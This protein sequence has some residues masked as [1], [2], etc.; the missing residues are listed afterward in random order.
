MID[1]DVDD[2]GK[3]DFNDPD[4]DGCPDLNIKWKDDDEN[5]V[6]INGD[7]DYDGIPN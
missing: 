2:D 6:I 5:W 4:G 7:R 3:P 1:K